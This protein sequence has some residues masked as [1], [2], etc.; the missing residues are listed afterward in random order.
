MKCGTFNIEPELAGIKQKTAKAARK[1]IPNK[2]KKSSHPK[3]IL[4]FTILSVW[5]S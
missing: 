2:N 5:G 1:N 4:L 3:S